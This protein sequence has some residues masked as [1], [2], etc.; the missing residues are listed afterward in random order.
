VVERLGI[1]PGTTVADVAAGTGK[2]TRQLVP[3]GARVIAVEP[4]PE[5]RAQLQAVLPDVLVLD[6]T[7]EELPLE[8]DSVDAIT[9][10]AAM[11]WFDLDRAVPEFH[12]A[13]KPGGAMAVIGPGRDLDQPLQRA[14]QEII[15]VYLPRISEFATWRND[16]ARSGLFHLAETLELPFDQQLDAEGLAE[17]VGTI[18]YVARLPDDDRA[19]VLE[20][21][22]VLGEAQ[23]ET[24]FP[25]RY[26]VT[27]TILRQHPPQY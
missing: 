26:R 3:T 14:V 6:G 20:R 1:G 7:A 13:L 19:R 25:F 17:R 5:M 27:A 18:S 23:P 9:V 10:A 12:R 15:G 4:L 16:V 24:P 8:D 21:V 11:H 22:R 2:L